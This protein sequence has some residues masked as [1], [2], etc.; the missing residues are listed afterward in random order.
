ME[1]MGDGITIPAE[2]IPRCPHCGGEAF[3]LGAGVRQLPAGQEVRGAVREGLPLCAR[4]QGDCK[5]LFLELGVG[6]MTP[7]FIQEPF[8]NLT[9]SFPHARYIARQR[10][11]Y[12][13]PAQSSWRTRAWPSWPTSARVLRDARDTMENGHDRAGASRQP[14]GN[15]RNP[16]LK[17]IRPGGRHPDRGQQRPVHHRGL[18][19]CSRTTRPLRTCLGTSSASTGCAAFCRA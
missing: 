1:A 6:R 4:T 2:L 19:T 10:Q 7:M 16:L 11:V 15:L 8:W 12:D 9:L 3:S 13:F 14:G 17:R 18:C 5:I